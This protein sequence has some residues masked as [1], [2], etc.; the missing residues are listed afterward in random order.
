[1][2]FEEDFF[3]RL[4]SDSVSVLSQ[5]MKSSLIETEDILYVLKRVF[6]ERTILK[7]NIIK[8]IE[9]Y[10]HKNQHHTIPYNDF[11]L[12][13]LEL[14]TNDIDDCYKDLEL[15]ISNIL[16]YYVFYE[17]D[18]EILLRFAKRMNLIEK[19]RYDWEERMRTIIES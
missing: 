3:E 7:R 1:M 16:D 13:I 17:E 8:G 14:V 15:T 5:I 10:M 18:K 6:Q 19:R 9:V 4:N 11:I 12:G 2:G